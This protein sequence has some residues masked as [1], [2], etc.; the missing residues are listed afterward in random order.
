MGWVRPN[1]RAVAVTAATVLFVGCTALF[2]V[3]AAPQVVGASH[4][5][6]V[7]SSSMSPTMHAGDIVL[8]DE[9]PPHE[10]ESG[11]I[12]TYEPPADAHEDGTDRVTHRVVGVVE[13]SDGVYFRTKG[14]ANEEP[15]PTLVP[16]NDVIGT[17]VFHVPYAGH[18]VLFGS[19]D[20][21]LFVLVVVPAVLLALNEVAA[22]RSASKADSGEQ[23]GGTPE[24][25][26]ETG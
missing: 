3:F 26:G 9:V 24:S 21:G 8:V 13:R 4:S 7:L 25:G 23:D 2:V 11:D 12:I 18:L 15:D 10:I 16:A 17:A 22:L 6:V 20:L 1:V 5:Y 14:D 19:S